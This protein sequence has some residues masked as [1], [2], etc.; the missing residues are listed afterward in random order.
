[1]NPLHLEYRRAQRSTLVLVLILTLAAATLDYFWG[2]QQRLSQ[3][4]AL[5]LSATED[6]EHQLSP[7]IVLLQFLQQQ[8]AQQLAVN[9]D[10]KV[11]VAADAPAASPTALAGAQWSLTS[12]RRNLTAQEVAM[13]LQLRPLMALSQQTV[14]GVK[15]LSYLSSQGIWYQAETPTGAVAEQNARQYWQQFQQ[16]LTQNMQ[17]QLTRPAISL[18]KVTTTP[19]RYVLAIGIFRQ[20]EFIGELIVEFDL[21]SLLKKQPKRS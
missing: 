14:A 20:S 21:P 6:L 18:R 4:Q 19:A 7:M 16:H 5:L 10:A 3:R 11:D 13:L 9:H 1:M 8:A 12:A 15:Q 17:Q 2:L